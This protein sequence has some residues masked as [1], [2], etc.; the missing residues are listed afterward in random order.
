MSPSIRLVMV[1]CTCVML[2]FALGCSRSP[3]TSYYV[4]NSAQPSVGTVQNK[5][6][7]VELRK[8]DI[9]TY[10]DRSAIVTRSP[11]G[12]QVN[13]SDYHQWA[14][15]LSTGMQRLLAEVLAPPLAEKNVALEPMDDNNRDSLQLFV[16]VLRFDGTLHADTVLEVRWSLRTTNDKMVAQGSFKELEPA[17]ASY[18]ALVKAQSILLTRFGEALV[19]PLSVACLRFAKQK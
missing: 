3:A 9:P 16:Q 17:G 13:L 18:E 15:S 11:S 12:V 7:S 5:K 14:E 8:V 10:L 6:V 19:D 1:L 4:L 2:S